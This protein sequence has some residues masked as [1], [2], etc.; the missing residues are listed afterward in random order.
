MVFDSEPSAGVA[1]PEYSIFKMLSAT[2]T[3]DSVTLKI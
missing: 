3:L 2:L 1:S